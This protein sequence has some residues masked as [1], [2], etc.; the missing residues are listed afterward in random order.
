ML[1]PFGELV[2]IGICC[3]VPQLGRIKNNNIGF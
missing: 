3:G 2:R 1:D